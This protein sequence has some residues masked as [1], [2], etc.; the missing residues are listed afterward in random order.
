MLLAYKEEEIYWGQKKQRKWLKEGEINTKFFHSSVKA[1]RGKK[2]IEKLK[3]VNGNFQRS[4]TQFE[5]VAVA[6]FQ[7]LFTSSS[8]SSFEEFFQ[9]F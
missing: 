3:D 1:S 5:E 8:P 4:K 9:G 6:Y 2:R 7:E